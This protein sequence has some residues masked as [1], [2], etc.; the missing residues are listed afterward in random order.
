MLYMAV[1]SVVPLA[2]AGVG[3][4]LLVLGLA[5]RDPAAHLTDVEVL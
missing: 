1:P 2:L 4:S 5:A 3:L